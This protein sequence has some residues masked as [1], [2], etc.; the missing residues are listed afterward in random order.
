MAGEVSPDNTAEVEAPENCP[1]CGSRLIRDGVHLFCENSL[2]CKPQLIKS[3]VHYAGREAMNIEGFSERTAEQLF[4]KLEIREISDLYN[5]TGQDLLGLEK[6]Q[7]KKTLNL[8]EAIE[9]SKDSTLDSFIYALGIPHVGKKTAR[10][11]A[12]R[13]QSLDTLMQASREELLEVPDI[14]EIVADSIV[15]FFRDDKIRDSISRLLAAGVRPRY[16]RRPA[17]DN[18][19]S[20]KTVVVTGSLS[21]YSRPEIEQLLAGLGAKVSGSV[22]RKTDYVIVGENPGSKYDKAKEIVA[23]NADAA[24]RIISEEEFQEMLSSA[25][26]LLSP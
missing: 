11:L 24:L 19:F 4:E 13:F 18:P 25:G 21:R 12:D 16:D 8:L 6:F 10:D 3:I 14:G 2:S 26:D 22:G 20:G 23:S 9:R 7:E 17:G 1:A 5:L 15:S